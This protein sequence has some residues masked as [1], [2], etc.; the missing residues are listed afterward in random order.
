[1]NG[2]V[3]RYKRTYTITAVMVP[4]EHLD[5]VREFFREIDADEKASAVLRRA[6]TASAT[7]ATATN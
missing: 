4:T 1:M 5:E 7:G 6:T 2:N 3:L